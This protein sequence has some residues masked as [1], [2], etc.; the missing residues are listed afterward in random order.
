MRDF[1][2]IQPGKFAPRPEWRLAADQRAAAFAKRHVTKHEQLH[3]GTRQLPPLVVGDHV[4]IQDQTGKTPRAWT[5]TGTIL[6][7]LPHHSYMVR[8]D[9]SNRVTK[10]NR[11]FMRSIKPFSPPLFPAAPLLP[12]HAPI[13]DTVTIPDP[14]HPTTPAQVPDT[15]T[16]TVPD[17][18][19]N[20]HDVVVTQTAP[21]P[22]P[23]LPAHL[24][25]RW[26]VGKK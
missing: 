11:Q 8:V 21:T 16:T 25:H 10:R 2:P 13:P 19:I 4:A 12:A 5:K 7:V 26:I 17:V 6:E 22:K 23:V 14:V 3:H 9:G 18:E 15:V 1:L 24:R 20:T